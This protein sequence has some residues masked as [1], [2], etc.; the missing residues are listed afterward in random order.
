MVTK[1]FSG[2]SQSFQQMVLGKLDIRMQKNE[3]G[4]LPNSTYKNQLKMGQRPKYKS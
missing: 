2:E 4:L 1:L 3:I